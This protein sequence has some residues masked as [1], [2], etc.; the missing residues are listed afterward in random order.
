ML[1]KFANVCKSLQKLLQTF[2]I[3]ILLQ[4]YHVGEVHGLH[5]HNAETIDQM[6]LT[7][8]TVGLGIC[9]PTS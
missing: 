7:R 4:P 3:T 6:I 1:Q 2:G 8:T 5:I 9:G